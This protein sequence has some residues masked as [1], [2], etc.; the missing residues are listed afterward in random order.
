MATL[1]F[2]V[3]TGASVAALDGIALGA[4]VGFLVGSGVGTGTNA[5][6]LGDMVGLAETTAVGAADATS[7]GMAVTLANG[8][9]LGLRDIEGAVVFS[10]TGAWVG[11][12]VGAIVSVTFGIEGDEVGSSLVILFIGRL[13]AGVCALTV[14]ISTI[15]RKRNSVFVFDAMFT[16]YSYREAIRRNELIGCMFC[17]E[18]S[19]YFP[20]GW[21]TT[22]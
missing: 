12:R 4:P 22:Q 17:N 9:A 10:A 7:D 5:V 21:C 15:H 8:A 2:S 20:N 3:G 6:G 11:G 1:T 14:I 18:R 19:S 13:G 16:V